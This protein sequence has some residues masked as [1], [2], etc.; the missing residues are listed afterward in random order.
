M[1]LRSAAIAV[2]EVSARRNSFRAGICFRCPPL[3][4]LAIHRKYKRT[5]ELRGAAIAVFEVSSIFRKT[6]LNQ[7]KKINEST[8]LLFVKMKNPTSY[9]SGDASSRSQTRGYLLIPFDRRISALKDDTTAARP[10]SIANALSALDPA[11]ISPA[12]LNIFSSPSIF[13]MPRSTRKGIISSYHTRA[14]LSPT[15]KQ[16]SSFFVPADGPPQES[17][18]AEEP[19]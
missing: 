16:S 3:L 19:E 2:F 18:T 15:T 11:D 6:K 12:K 14:R 7:K 4:E 9:C 5:K 13:T 1:E 10:G 8:E 17:A